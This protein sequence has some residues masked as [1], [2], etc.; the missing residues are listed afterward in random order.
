M[1]IT[2]I[3][4]RG[5]TLPWQQG[6]SDDVLEDLSPQLCVFSG[7]A[8][9]GKSAVARMITNLLYGKSPEHAEG[10]TAEGGVVIHG[11]GGEYLLRRV[12]DGRR[13]GR[14]TIAS[15]GGS[16]T[17]SQ[18]IRNLLDGIDPTLLAQLY[19]IDFRY[20]PP[21]GFLANEALTGR[22]SGERDNRQGPPRSLATGN[23]STKSRRE[24]ETLI[25]RRDELAE[26]IENYY[27]EGRSDS[28]VLERQLQEVD[29]ALAE[30]RQRQKQLKTELAD[31]DKRLAEI[32]AHLRYQALAAHLI[33]DADRADDTAQREIEALEEEIRRS[34][35]MIAEVE[36]RAA[37]VRRDLA[38][39]HP[40]GAAEDVS[41]LAEQRV[42]LQ[43]MERL[44][45]DLEAEI[46]LLARSPET[47]RPSADQAHARMRPAAE[48]LRQQI[49]VLCGQ[50]TTQQQAAER[51]FLELESER[52][53]RV[54]RDLSDQLETLLSRRQALTS[55]QRLQA[56]PA[57][58]S[59][60]API[61]DAC[62]CTGHEQAI[63]PTDLAET[64]A[65]KDAR[66]LDELQGER[67]A[68]VDTWRVRTD[69]LAEVCRETEAAEQ[70][71]QHLQRKRS[72]IAD[73]GA[74]DELR[75]E[76]ARLEAQ[77]ETCLDP[78]LSEAS[79]SDSWRA[80]DLLAQLTDGRF[81]QIR[82]RGD[83][84]T[85]NI[86]D[87][88]GR[89]VR[90]ATLSAA[91]ADQAAL[92]I[93]LSIIA[94][95][96]EQGIELPLVL[97]E[98]FLRLDAAEA[99][100][101]AGVLEEFAAAGHQLLVFTGDR[102]ACRRFETL[103]VAV[104]RLGTPAPAAPASRPTKATSP[105]AATTFRIVRESA[106]VAAPTEDAG[107]RH[108][109]TA[110]EHLDAVH[111]LATE[112]TLDRFPVLG[113]ATLEAFA[114]LELQTVGDLLAADPEE[115]ARGLSRDRV[116][117]QT[118]RLWQAH[119]LLMCYVPGVSLDV[120]QVLTACEVWSP[121]D[122]LDRDPSD[123]IEAAEE[124]FR[125]ERGS[126]FMAVRG[127]FND[128]GIRAWRQMAKRDRQRWQAVAGAGR[129]G[130]RPGERGQKERT[131]HS[132]RR[133]A[134]AATTGSVTP[135]R[136][137]SK[138]PAKL[139]FL[140]DASSPVVDAPS[141]GP[142][143]A[144]RLSSAG[145]RTVADLLHADASSTAAE[146]NVRHISPAAIASWQYQAR[147]VCCIPELRGYAAQLLVACGL[148]E[149][150]QV[151]NADPEELARQVRGFAKTKEGQRILRDR[152]APEAEKIARWVDFA[153]HQRPLEAA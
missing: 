73:R 125:T 74:L 130:K 103:G 142:K 14:L 36:P 29:Q 49:Y 115:V 76:L 21:I 92:A 128:A 120:A 69:Q 106:D 110:S 85:P 124:F 153:T 116:T 7:P 95:Y 102:E 82:T 27:K 119:T 121:A 140:L 16:A 117:P 71:W 75:E 48:L 8:G 87:R 50:I 12:D 58:T 5:N 122:L 62:R 152:S 138:R 97:D 143:T 72:R 111:Y 133:K 61:A 136:E 26:A 35:A 134:R 149:P 123:L 60:T 28:A 107:H 131:D 55:A 54:Q 113:S 24:L 146:L 81:V 64:H 67:A 83:A 108:R 114:A 4:L 18:T 59:P 89:V 1:R 45:D 126:R 88:S 132:D 118:V 80:S 22:T 147:L 101:M 30:G 150:D 70:Q 9:S 56:R 148:V 46:A 51:R 86:V 90:W 20:P 79:T 38:A 112:D 94:R 145:I 109:A 93:A 52:L 135:V 139:R 99:A 63:E 84:Q 65:P 104:R 53:E 2:E 40:S 25:R 151:A 57:L 105:P 17:D 34:R 78:P 15:R 66:L 32:E 127:Y 137:R 33:D 47:R 13:Q 31:L 42:A 19:A 141:I 100:I 3:Q 11:R 91:E 6:S 77:I 96:A 44:L 129:R 43:A 41:G 68:L 98:P 23:A 39:L 144:E 37:K 10:H